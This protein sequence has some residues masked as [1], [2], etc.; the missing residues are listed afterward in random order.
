MSASSTE[1][2]YMSTWFK[3]N[4]LLVLCAYAFYY[5]PLVLGALT[6]NNGRTFFRHKNTLTNS[7][8]SLII[9]SY[10]AQWITITIAE[11]FSFSHSLVSYVGIHIKVKWVI[12]DVSH[13]KIDLRFKST[14][15]Y[16]FFIVI[17]FKCSFS[18]SNHFSNSQSL[19]D[20]VS[21]PP[22][23]KVVNTIEHFGYHLATVFKLFVIIARITIFALAIWQHKKALDVSAPLR[24]AKV[25]QKATQQDAYIQYARTRS[26]KGLFTYAWHQSMT[27][28]THQGHL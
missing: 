8:K 22:V 17:L 28:N 6:K 21:P 2:D 24:A 11:C 19:W 5:Y 15:K 7:P 14:W 16:L 1:N 23:Q 4:M 10:L 27:C 9:H 13:Q 26:L 3:S 18:Y 12:G 20:P 25:L